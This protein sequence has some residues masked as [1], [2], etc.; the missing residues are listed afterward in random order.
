MC[1]LQT[2]LLFLCHTACFWFY[3]HP[4]LIKTCPWPLFPISH[5]N[6]NHLVNLLT[7]LHGSFLLSFSEITPGS[8]LRSEHLELET[9]DE[10]D[11]VKF[12]FLSMIYNTQYDLSYFHP[13]TWKW[14]DFTFFF[15]MNI[16]LQYMCI[17]FLLFF[18]QL[19][20]I[21]VVSIC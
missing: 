5:S 20:D 13:F 4:T 6:Q 11:H 2:F 15:Q 8:T 16:I 1:L 19:K 17:I 12:F 9:S 18:Q 3:H 21:S 10:R 14:C 7:P